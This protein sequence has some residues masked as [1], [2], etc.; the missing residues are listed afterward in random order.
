L[1]SAKNAKSN[2]NRPNAGFTMRL[3]Y[4]YYCDFA[5]NQSLC[6]IYDASFSDCSVPAP[7]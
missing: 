2:A 3:Q 7:T 5:T 1:L 6:V 4:Y